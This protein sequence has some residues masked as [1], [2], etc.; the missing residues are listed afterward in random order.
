MFVRSKSTEDL[1]SLL[2]WLTEQP[3]FRGRCEVVRG[4]PGPGEMGAG[5][6]ALHI[7]LDGTGPAL[8]T[9]LWGWLAGRRRSRTTIEVTTADHRRVTVSSD[10]PDE[11]RRQLRALLEKTGPR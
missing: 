6:E 1:A 3:E 11:A 7:L 8:V 5:A 9:G 10:D 4:R 2:D